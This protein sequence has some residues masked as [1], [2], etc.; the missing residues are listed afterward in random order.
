VRT[1]QDELERAIQRVAAGS[2]RTVFAGRT[3]RGVHA[4]GQV[5]SI[6]ACWRSSDAD[7]QAALNATLPDDVIVAAVATAR[8]DFHAR[9]DALSR[10]YRYRIRVS[11]I[12]PV[13]DRR[14]VWWRRTAIDA[15]RASHACRLFVGRHA[16]GT[17]AGSGWSQ[18]KSDAQLVRTVQSCSWHSVPDGTH[19]L[20]ITADGFLPHMVRNIVAAIVRVGSGVAEPEW[21]DELIH[22][23]DRR[24]LGDAAPP[25][26]LVLW[27]V[28]YADDEPAS[29]PRLDG[30]RGDRESGGRACDSRHTLPER[31]T[32]SD[33][34]TSSTPMG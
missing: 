18:R 24:R 34:G 15:E 31:Q 4:L 7:L 2:G 30:L 11:D 3:D 23:N 6:D 10:E 13:L 28:E 19:E 20:R 1:V 9:F 17:F 26:G 16:F 14:Y 5:V 33:S 25:H 8:Q 32:S 29:R 21:I 12:L 27:R 22:A